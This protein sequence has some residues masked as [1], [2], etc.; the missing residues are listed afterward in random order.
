MLNRIQSHVEKWY[1]E[2]GAGFLLGRVDGN[3]SVVYEILPIMNAREKADRHNRYLITAEDMLSGEQSAIKLGLDIIGVF[4]SHPDHPE[5]PS[6]FDREWALP[7]YS[8][9]ITSVQGGVVE[10]SRSWKLLE[11]RS[12]FE[13]EKIIILSEM[14]NS[15]EVQIGNINQ[16]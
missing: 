9:L 6:E 1:P 14:I 15:S 4:H 16:S 3:Q 11:D 12:A 7:W 13:E 10:K 8:Y 2:E 5:Y